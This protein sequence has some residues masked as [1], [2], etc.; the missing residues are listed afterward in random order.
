MGNKIVKGILAVIIVAAILADAMRQHLLMALRA[1]NDSGKSELPVG[2]AAM[3]ASL[4]N[5]SFGESHV[6]TS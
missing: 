2:A 3:L 6:Y 5:F 1:G 4:R